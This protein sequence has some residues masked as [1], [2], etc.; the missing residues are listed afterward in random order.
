MTRDVHAGQNTSLKRHFPA[1]AVFVVDLMAVVEPADV[2]RRLQRIPNYAPEDHVAAPL[3]VS[4]RFAHHL[5]PGHWKE[6]TG[7]DETGINLDSD[8]HSD[9][10]RLLGIRTDNVQ[11]NLGAELGLRA[12]LTLVVAAVLLADVLH[13]QRPHAVGGV[14]E[15]V[16][17][18]VRDER[19]PVHGKNVVVHHSNPRHRLVAH[20]AD[21]QQGAIQLAQRESE[22]HGNNCIINHRHIVVPEILIDAFVS[23]THPH[24][25]GVWERE[26]SRT[27]PGGY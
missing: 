11:E 13:L 3:H 4:Y 8:T 1:L 10:H 21:L 6:G 14:V 12:H 2:Q 25:L 16:E 19:H 15:R 9:S 17:A 18:L 22:G 27:R 20:L 23:P 24:T 7:Q 5:R 26:L